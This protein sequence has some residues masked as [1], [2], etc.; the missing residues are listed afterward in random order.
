MSCLIFQV[1]LI[2][3]LSHLFF[4]IVI[5]LSIYLLFI[6]VVFF[7]IILFKLLGSQ[8]FISIAFFFYIEKFYPTRGKAHITN[9]VTT[10]KLWSET[11]TAYYWPNNLL[12]Y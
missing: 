1:G 10:K 3:V 6:A 11:K 7:L 8:D 2:W 9:V 4:L 12:K 5:F